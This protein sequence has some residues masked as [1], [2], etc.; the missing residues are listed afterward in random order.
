MA[1]VHSLQETQFPQA[2]DSDFLATVHYNLELWAKLTLFLLSCFCLSIL[3][4]QQKR[5]QDVG[6]GPAS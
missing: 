1:H 3:S 2:P 5:I 6:F 4:Q